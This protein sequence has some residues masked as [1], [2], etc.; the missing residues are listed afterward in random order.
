MNKRKGQTGQALL[1]VLVVVAV[2]AV[3]VAPAVRLGDTAIRSGELTTRH[4]RAM[5][6]ID[7]AHEYVAWKL[8]NDA[9]ASEF[10][11]QGSESGEFTLDVCGV[12]VGINVAM[13]AVPG[14]GGV[15]LSDPNMRIR[16][17][18]WVES[19]A[20]GEVSN[21]Y[22]GTITYIIKLEQISD[23]TS[24]SLEA[25]YD[26]LTQE[27]WRDTDSYIDGSTC[28]SN[29][30]SGPWTCTEAGVRDLEPAV[31]LVGGGKHRLQWPSQFD[32]SDESNGFSD[33]DPLDSDWAGFGT[34]AEGQAKYLKFSIDASKLTISDDSVYYNWVILRPWG[35]VSG[36]QALLKVG[37]PSSLFPSTGGLIQTD[38]Q[39]YPSLVIPGP[40]NIPVWYVIIMD[41]TDVNPHSIDS[42]ID[43]LPPGFVL[44][45]TL[46]AAELVSDTPQEFQDMVTA[47]VAERTVATQWV[48]PTDFDASGMVVDLVN[49]GT[50][51]DPIWRQ[52]ITW[53]PKFNIDGTETRYI[54]LEAQVTQDVSGNYYNEASAVATSLGLD[55]HVLNDIT[56]EEQYYTGYSWNA[57]NVMVPS[58]DSSAS[59]DGVTIDSNMMFIL[60]G[61]G[62]GVGFTSYQVK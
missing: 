33:P 50:V 28:I 5:Y 45:R 13:Q 14:S 24:E 38:K 31:Q 44:P 42:V 8:L 58:F 27:W 34:F 6:A 19:P 16:P 17:T 40:E 62:I 12:E 23:D 46:D 37:E 25:I 22:T 48:L 11:G 30:E 35:T 1:L 26:V 57:G 7:G 51:E 60:G 21:G 15:G 56:T 3:M 9:F 36:P 61:A 49:F 20:G 59:A 39:A 47:M 10:S 2:A 4:V 43:V 52:Q 53:E 18:K 29:S 41:N 32:I 54:I 55:P